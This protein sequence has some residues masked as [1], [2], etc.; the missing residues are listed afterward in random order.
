M[1]PDS[2]MFSLWMQGFWIYLERVRDLKDG[3][4]L[5][6]RG[7]GVDHASRTLASEISWED[8]LLCKWVDE[9]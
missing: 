7:D 1:G 5:G 6:L 3:L 8:P 9:S 4:W 2:G